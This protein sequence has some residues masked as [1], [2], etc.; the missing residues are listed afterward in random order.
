MTGSMYATTKTDQMKHMLPD[1]GFVILGQPFQ[2]AKDPES[3][4]ILCVRS[5][6]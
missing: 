2:S 6:L 5:T 1:Y 4:L 3:N